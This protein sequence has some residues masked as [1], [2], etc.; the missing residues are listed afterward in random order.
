MI[1]HINR[2]RIRY[3]LFWLKA[4]K[5]EKK[6]NMTEAEIQQLGLSQDE[7]E[8]IWS[9]YKSPKNMTISDFPAKWDVGI[10]DIDTMLNRPEKYWLFGISRFKVV[11]RPSIKVLY[12]DP[13][14]GSLV[15]KQEVLYDGEILGQKF[16][17]QKGF[18][19]VKTIGEKAVTVVDFEKILVDLPVRDSWG[20]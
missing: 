17:A 9:F 16:F 6:K 1:D 15:E 7:V 3:C 2:K 13:E 8:A 4:K 18:A 20:D 5:D 19:E 14:T 12:I 10:D 11:K